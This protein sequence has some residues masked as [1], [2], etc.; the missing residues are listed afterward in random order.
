MADPVYAPIMKGRQAE[1]AALRSIQPATRQNILPLLEIVPG[2]ADEPAAMRQV[3]ERTALKLKDWT[4]NRLL[5]DSGLLVTDVVITGSLGAVGF[6]A[7]V[8]SERG[9][10]VTP[11]VRLADPDLAQEDAAAVHTDWSG[12]IAIRLGP[13][14]LDEETEDLDAAL[15][16]L[17]ARLH[18]SRQEVDLI[19]DVGVVDG[20]FGVRAGSRLLGDVLR[21]LANVDAWRTIIAASGAFPADLSALQPWTIGE[22]ARYDAALFDHLQ[23]RRRIPRVPIYGDYAVAHPALPTGPAFPPAP[24]LRYTVADKWLTLKGRRNDPRG[25]DQFYDICDMIAGHAEFVGAALG[26]AD[27]RIAASRQDR[28]G[29]ASTWQEIGTTHHLDYVVQRLT[30]LGEP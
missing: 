22:P 26:R 28:P 20:E 24:S 18:V 14:D 3:I 29:N 4:G 8:V 2:P 19:L 23:Q 21:G 12:G 25:H 11:V 7:A 15:D 27:E 6:A 10:T 30:T 17:L 9:V 1:F 16:A 13:E 5:L